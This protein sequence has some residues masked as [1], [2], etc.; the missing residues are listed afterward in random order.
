MPPVRR[1]T[2]G[3]TYRINIEAR[4][5]RPHIHLTYGEYQAS[6]ALDTLEVLA[7]SLPSDRLGEAFQW[8]SRHQGELT[9]MYTHRFEPGAIK[10]LAD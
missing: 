10:L 2:N 8:I 6:V 3:V 4:H 7:G 1:K 5:Q 9:D